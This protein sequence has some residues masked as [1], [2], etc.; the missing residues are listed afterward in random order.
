MMEKK[1]LRSAD[2]I[3]AII[4]IVFGLWVF[5]TTVTT[6]PM[7]DSWGGVQNVWYVSPALFPIFISV[8]IIILG[9]MLL[10]NAIKE[11][12]N[13][14]FFEKLSQVKPGLSDNML[15]FLAIVLIFA[16]F[17]YIYIPRYDFFLSALLS[18]TVFM[19]MFYLDRPELLKKLTGFFFIGSMIF[20]FLA[21]FKI[22]A[23]LKSRYIYLMD[24]FLFLFYLLYIWYGWKQVRH[25][26]EL[27]SKYSLTLLISGAMPLFVIPLFKYA[28]LVPFPV[29][30]GAIEI[31][32]TFWYSPSIKALRK[33]TG[34]YVVLLGIFS[35]FAAII[36]VIYFKFLREP[37]HTKA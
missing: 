26:A 6:F 8:G 7:K 35:I 3:S 14:R 15:R 19:S 24:I 25:D 12:G 5:I 34:P 29:E 4:L 10:L 22:D 33:V 21:V 17:V 27:T 20:L 37:K 13:A 9:I 23:A 31:M 30:G 11:G 28:L 36:V 2:F 16:A 32:S 1:E 18:L